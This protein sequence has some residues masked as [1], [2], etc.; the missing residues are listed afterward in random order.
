MALVQV[1]RLE[2]R[3][4]AGDRVQQRVPPKRARQRKKARGRR[5]AGA[6]DLPRRALTYGYF[7]ENVR[8]VENRWTRGVDSS[9]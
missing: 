9:R 5:R 3:R 7:N 8:P 1:R 2:T 6:A 4:D